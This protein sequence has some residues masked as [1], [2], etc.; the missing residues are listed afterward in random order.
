MAIGLALT[1]LVALGTNMLTVSAVPAAY[2]VGKIYL[3]DAGAALYL[4]PLRWVV[5]FAPLAFVLFFSFKI[6][7]MAASTRRAACSSP[8]R[9]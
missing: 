5:M 2:R 7:T 6:G 1:G 9:R 8:S 3:T 4:S